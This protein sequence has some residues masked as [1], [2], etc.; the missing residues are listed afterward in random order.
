MWKSLLSVKDD[1]DKCN[2]YRAHNGQ[3]IG[4][5]NKQWHG[6]STLKELFPGLYL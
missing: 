6:N 5:W 2:R 1:F 4:F 3:R